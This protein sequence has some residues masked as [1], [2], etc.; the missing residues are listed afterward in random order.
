VADLS[1]WHG[2]RRPREARLAPAADRPGRTTLM[3]RQSNGSA[4]SQ[5]PL[6]LVSNRGPVTFDVDGSFT[7][8]GGGLVTALTGLASHRDVVWI[9]SAM[10]DGDMRKAEECDGRP[11]TV[12]AASGNDYEVRLVASE[13]KAYDRFYNVVSN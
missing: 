5:R 12:E 3:A 7:R 4:G 9:A 8:G 11:F 1:Q 2:T 13:P 6:V 10:T